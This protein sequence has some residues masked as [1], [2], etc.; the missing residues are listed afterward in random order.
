MKLKQF[1][2]LVAE[3]LD[4][5]PEEIAKHMDN[6]AITVADW[7]SHAELESTGRRSPYDLLGLYQGVPL[8]QRGQSYNLLPPDR[9]VLFRRPLEAAARSPAAM[10]ELVRNTVVHEIAHH[11]G[12]SD[13][14]IK[15]IG[16]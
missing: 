1:E 9:I 16:Y 8:T 6:I 7:P 15:E 3:A 11:F 13:E 4:E 2:E 5:L 12:I 10:R 14:R